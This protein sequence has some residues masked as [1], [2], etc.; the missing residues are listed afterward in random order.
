MP[1]ATVFHGHII[2]DWLKGS[3]INRNN[4]G[5][6]AFKLPGRKY[7]KIFLSLFFRRLFFNFF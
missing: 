2:I 5:K 7:K 6:E 1:Q 4:M 3:F